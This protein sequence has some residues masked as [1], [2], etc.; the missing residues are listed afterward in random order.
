[1]LYLFVCLVLLV[2]LFMEDL[3]YCPPGIFATYKD[4]SKCSTSLL[5]D[6][7]VEHNVLALCERVLITLYLEA[8]LWLLSH[9]RYWSVW[10]GFLYTF[11]GRVPSALGLLKDPK[12]GWNHLVQLL[13]WLNLMDVSTWLMCWNSS[14]CDSC[15]ITKVSSTYLFH[16]LGVCHAI[17]MAL[18]SKT[19]YRCLPQVGSLVI[20]WQH[21]WYVQKIDY[22]TGSRC[23]LDKSPATSRCY[24]LTKW[25]LLVVLCPVLVFFLSL[26]W[27]LFFESIWTSSIHYYIRITE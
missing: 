5:M 21:L 26:L 8:K 1:M 25:F 19:S 7:G 2:F 3:L 27:H 24:L 14:S 10:V 23:W 15:W 4:F 9:W 17:F 12:M 13:L 22:Q 16:I 6:S 18:S 20:P 11:V